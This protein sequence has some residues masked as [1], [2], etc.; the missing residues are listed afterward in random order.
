MADE[1]D[2]IFD[3]EY[4]E[5]VKT[6]KKKKKGIKLMEESDRNIPYSESKAGRMFSG[7]SDPRKSSPNRPFHQHI[8]PNIDSKINSPSR[9][10]ELSGN[11]PKQASFQTSQSLHYVNISRNGVYEGYEFESPSKNFVSTQNDPRLSTSQRK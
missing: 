11:R 6:P 9:K 8:T 3:P 7:I 5:T 10:G 4:Q 1:L 2:Y